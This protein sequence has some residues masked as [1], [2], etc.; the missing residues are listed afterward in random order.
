MASFRDLSSDE[1]RAHR[2]TVLLRLLIRTSQIEANQL[3]DRL[4]AAGHAN[5]ATSYIALL[6]NVDTEGTRI[7]TLAER[8]GTTRQAVSQLVKAIEAAGYLERRPDPDDGRGVLVRHTATGRGLLADALAAMADI[9]AG[10]ARLIGDERM[11]A[12]KAALGEIA[13]SVDP[14]STLGRG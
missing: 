6:G 14:A 1:L 13:D 5:V 12:L 8:L 3:I 4:H 10:Y 7:V 9:E 11:A 2:E